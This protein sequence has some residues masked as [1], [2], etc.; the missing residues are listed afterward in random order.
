MYLQYMEVYHKLPSRS[1][2]TASLCHANGSISNKLYPF[3][4]LYTF[5][6][7]HR[8]VPILIRTIGSSPSLLGIISD[9]PADSRD[10]LMQVQVVLL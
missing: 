9:P 6:A 4:I 1:V 3:D 10:L 5:Q 7:V 8:Q 2:L